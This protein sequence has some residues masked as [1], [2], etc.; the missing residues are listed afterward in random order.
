M[1]TTVT[2]RKLQKNYGAKAMALTIFISLIFLIL[3]YKAVCRGLVLGAI[4]STIN[5][6]WMAQTLHRQIKADRVKASI[7]AFISIFCRYSFAAIPVVIAIKFPRFN[8]AATIVGLF[9]VQLVIL[10]D[11]LYRNFFFSGEGEK[12][13]F[14]GRI[15]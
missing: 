9:M 7:S 15:R 8:L 6:V 1:T 10:A 12:G 13:A 3:G 11:H 2:A 14:Y 5:F 4:F